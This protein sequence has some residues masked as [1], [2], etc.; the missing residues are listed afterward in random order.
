MAAGGGAGGGAGW[1]TR[2]GAIGGIG[3]DEDRCGAGDGL[4]D[5]CPPDKGGLSGGARRTG[6]TGTSSTGFVS[7]DSF[8][9]ASA[10]G[11]SILGATGPLV[12]LDAGS[13]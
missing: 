1:T 9:V 13:S 10:T 5:K 3:I 7:G 6:G 11:T 2:G 12:D 4:L 8:C